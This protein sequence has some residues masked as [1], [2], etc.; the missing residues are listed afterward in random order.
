VN[1]HERARRKADISFKSVGIPSLSYV[2]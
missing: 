2:E 1:A